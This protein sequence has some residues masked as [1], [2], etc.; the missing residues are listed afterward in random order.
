MVWEPRDYRQRVAAEGLVGFEVVHAET[1]LHIGARANLSAQAR[2]LV[3][4][5]RADIE[6]Y[7]AA[8]PRFAE[9]FVPVEVEPGAPEVVTAMAEAAH[10][11]GV[12]PMAAV[13]GAV[14]ER[15]ARGL[16]PVSADVIVEN[17]G[18][19]YLCGRTARRV[20]L[21]AGDSPFSGTAAIELPA[22]ALPVG[23][24]TSSGRV[25]H[26][27]SLG[28][29]H[30]ATVVATDGALA[31][32][33][34]TATGNRVHGSEDVEH[35]LAFALGVRGVRGAVIIAGDR[36]GVAGDVRLARVGAS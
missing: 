26:S 10:A 2:S 6:A 35:A 32:A 27:V 9:S 36:I 25:G 20:L 24:C 28:T 8:H 14:A 5:V 30:A 33:V 7:I 4:G 17:G 23:V 11:A 3:A 15:V 22:D 19:I 34:A 21:V 31:D 12:G 29:A 18:D 13:A 1:D 16:Q